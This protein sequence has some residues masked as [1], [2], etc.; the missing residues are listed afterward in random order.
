MGYW[1]I[2]KTRV[3]RISGGVRQPIGRSFG[4]TNAFLDLGGSYLSAFGNLVRDV[5]GE[6][7]DFQGVSVGIVDDAFRSTLT[8]VRRGGAHCGLGCYWGSPLDD[9]SSDPQVRFATTLG[10]R[11]S[12]VRGKFLDEQQVVIPQL[13]TI[14][15]IYSRTDTTGGIYFNAQAILLRRNFGLGDMQWDGRRGICARLDRFWR[16]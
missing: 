15:T 12:H 14:R 16:F 3:T 6:E 4:S 5:P 10:G 8:E 11:L 13:I 1:L 7:L 2:S 9:R